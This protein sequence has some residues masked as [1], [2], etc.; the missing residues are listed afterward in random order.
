MGLFKVNEISESLAV[1]LSRNP[2]V[3]RILDERNRSG[4]GDGVANVVVLG[5]V[6]ML[7]FM[8]ARLFPCGLRMFSAGRGPGLGGMI[9]GEPTKGRPSLQSP[10]LIP[11]SS[12]GSAMAGA[13]PSTRMKLPLLGPK[14]SPLP[15]AMHAGWLGAPTPYV[16]GSGRP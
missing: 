4:P 10:Q 12:K 14:M 6:G 5:R 7:E 9:T 8:E 13:F 16:L 11:L 1:S 2:P 15:G 3:V